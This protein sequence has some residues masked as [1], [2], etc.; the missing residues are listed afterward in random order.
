[1]SERYLAKYIRISEDDED[2]G[3]EKKESNSIVNQRKLLDS[4]IGSHR[5]LSKYPVKEFVDEGISG[6][7]FHRP[8]V[9]RMLMEV[10]QGKIF[11]IVVKD[12][13][14]FGRN[15]IEVGDYIEQIFPFLDVRFIAVSDHFDSSCNPVGLDIGFKN[16]IHD[17]YSRDLSKKVKSAMAILQQQGRYN[18]GGIPYG[19]KLGEKEN[20]PLV[21]DQEAA[22]VVK[23]IFYLAGEGN[24]TTQIAGILNEEG[25]PTPGVYKKEHMG[26]QYKVKNE[27][28]ALWT[29]SRINSIIRDEAYRGTYVGHK[30]STVKPGVTKSNDSSEYIKI[31]NHHARLIEED[32]FW[33]AQEIIVSRP[34]KTTNRDVPR[35]IS[36][37]KGK[38]KCGGCGYNMSINRTAKRPYY[39]CRMGK[40]C[41][42]Y[43]KIKVE[44][45][46]ETVGDVLQKLVETSQEQRELYQNERKQILSTLVKVQDEKRTIEMK[47]EHCR[48]SR[49]ELY[50]Q[51]KEELLTKEEYMIRKEELT[52]QEVEYQEKLEL[53]NRRLAENASVWEKEEQKNKLAVLA[54]KKG[55]TKELGDELIEWVKVY[56]E[57][58]IE[59][60]WRFSDIFLDEVAKSE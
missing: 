44:P 23:R 7:N 49:L 13:S 6:V 45:L 12:L 50:R 1:M 59:I 3:E 19:Y 36:V 31:E 15:Y 60:K 17:L 5:E 16:L 21:P 57:G 10:R 4:Y 22:E 26:I 20:M 53:L 56:G 29:A 46:E 58:K 25:I 54:E 8:G 51:W 47:M 42:S 34:R 30:A 40:G 11:C 35:Q 38:V 41:G 39:Y 2:V 14:R 48:L 9:Q 18:G 32:L 33:K 52:V 28:R 55:L 24:K 43:T 37:L 27:K